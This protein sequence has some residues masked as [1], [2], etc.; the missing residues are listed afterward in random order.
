MARDY[1]LMGVSSWHL[2]VAAGLPGSLGCNAVVVWRIRNVVIK[3]D[4]FGGTRYFRPLAVVVEGSAHGPRLE[5]GLPEWSWP[6]DIASVIR[7]LV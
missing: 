3:G 4:C 1:P 5:V 7:G 2:L 6:H